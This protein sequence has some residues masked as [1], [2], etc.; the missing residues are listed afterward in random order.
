MKKVVIIAHRHDQPAIVNNLQ[1]AGLVE[2][3]EISPDVLIGDGLADKLFAARSE[4]ISFEIT[5]FE[6]VLE[7]LE[8]AQPSAPGFINGLIKKRVV[9]DSEEFTTIDKKVNFE[10]L[11]EKCEDLDDS[12]TGL[13]QELQELI[14]RRSELSQWLNLDIRFDRIKISKYVGLTI[15]RIKRENLK[16]L[17]E[18]LAAQRTDTDLTIVGYQHQTAGLVL[19]YYAPRAGA[20]ERVLSANGFERIEIGDLSL[21]ASEETDKLDK[22][23]L[24]VEGEIQGLKDE[25]AQLV[26]HSDDIY[27]LLDWLQGRQSR[28]VAQSRFGQTDSTFILEGWVE[29]RNIY[30][31]EGMLVAHEAVVDFD[32]SEPQKGDKVPVVIRNPGW[33]RP[34][35]TLTRLYGMPNYRE[36]DPTPIMAAF[37][38]LFFGLSI[39]DFGYGVVLT[40]FCLWLRSRLLITAVGK[41]WL[42]LFA[43]GGIASAIVGIFTGSYFSLDMKVLP[44]ILRRLVVIDPLEQAFIFLLAT[45]ALGVVHILAGLGIEFWDSWRRGDYEDAVNMS[46]AKIAVLISG[47]GAVS[48]W[49][50][51]TV[52]ERKDAFYTG[53]T[54]MGVLGLG[55]S[56]LI[57]VILSGG[58]LRWYLEVAKKTF[59]STGQGPGKLENTVAIVLLILVM[60]SMLQAF[61]NVPR[62]LTTISIVVIGMIINSPTRQAIIRFL[63]GLYNLYGLTTYIGDILSYSRLMALGLA[64]FLIGFAINTI[65]GLV[66]GFSPWGMP[67]GILLALVIAI[68]FHIFN[69]VINLLGA[70]VHP[71]R[72]QFVEFFS[73]FYENGGRPFNPFSYKTDRLIFKEE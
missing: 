10:A 33:L 50:A 37:F 43:L 55:I 28:Y 64:T 23:I 5:K 48:G 14:S 41:E 44:E 69:L 36:L 9:V 22:R 65:A 68:P 6:F 3:L 47:A 26:T 31:I 34:F 4:Q 57:F 66:I 32:F 38:F 12:L 29:D 70:F 21:T 30:K 54:S 15:G 19:I 18:T 49:F 24:R 52:F 58:T 8:K 35:E 61:G 20:V 42:T 73:K 71:L 45:W 72:L 46:L 11:Y 51:M 59:D 7:F 17:T 67:L 16:R 1:D 56:S 60:V 39:G 63:G 62:S 53:L 25:I 13:T 2:I 40:A 27:V